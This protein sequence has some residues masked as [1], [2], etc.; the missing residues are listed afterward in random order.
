[1]EVTR[2]KCLRHDNK[3]TIESNLRWFSVTIHK[4]I[5]PSMPKTKIIKE[6]MLKTYLAFYE[7]HSNNSIIFL[8]SSYLH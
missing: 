1:M 7:Q 6:I 8:Q 4:N 3:T 2:G 5:Y